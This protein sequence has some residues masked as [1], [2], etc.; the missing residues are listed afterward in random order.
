MNK[1]HKAFRKVQVVFAI[2]SAILILDMQLPKIVTNEVIQRKEV[3]A[4]EA[5]KQVTG[6]HYKPVSFDGF[7]SKLFTPWPIGTKFKVARTKVFGELWTVYRIDKKGAEHEQQFYSIYDGSIMFYLMFFLSVIGIVG[8]SGDHRK[9]SPGMLALTAMV[10]VATLL[11]AF[12]ALIA[13]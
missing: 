8:L 10:E 7:A 12:F 11:F 3:V 6:N 13:F 5:D 4:R 2:A 1:F 9:V